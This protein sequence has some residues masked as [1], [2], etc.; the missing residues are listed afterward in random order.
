MSEE[1][2]TLHHR[3]AELLKRHEQ[4][5]A[6]LADLKARAKEQDRKF[7]V[8]RKIILGAAVQAHAKLN[9]AFREELRKA[10][11]AAVTRPHDR[12]C[13]AGVFSAES[14]GN[15]PDSVALHSLRFVQ[16][17]ASAEVARR[18][19]Q[20]A[21]AGLENNCGA[22]PASG[23]T[24][25]LVI[26]EYSA[27]RVRSRGRSAASQRPHIRNSRIPGYSRTHLRTIITG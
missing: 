4:S 24:A 26:P 25:A 9:S 15:A 18:A 16:P 19:S 20:R 10:V 1:R 5:R 12:A 17:G 11:L 27:D 14:A 2:K 3:I 6:E 7:D 8:R 22:A 21:G 23:K 13:A